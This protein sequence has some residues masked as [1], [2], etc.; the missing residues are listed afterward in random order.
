MTHSGTRSCRPN[1]PKEMG[2]NPSFA[3]WPTLGQLELFLRNANVVCLNPSFAGWPTLGKSLPL[4]SLLL[5][6]VLI[7]LLLDDPLWATSNFTLAQ[8]NESLNPSF[9]GWPTLGKKRSVIYILVICLNP[10]F[11]GW[12]TLGSITKGT[13]R[14]CPVLIP[15]LLDDP[16]WAQK[17]S[18]LLLFCLCLNPSFAGWPTLGQ[19]CMNFLIL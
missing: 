15:L 10:S 12:P 14:L 18:P 4:L 17:L 8:I 7:P 2:L 11:A 6:L 1:Q 19:K 16:L 3:G 13:N 9:A 5:Y